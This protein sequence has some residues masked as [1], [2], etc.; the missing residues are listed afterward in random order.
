[1]H[2][3]GHKALCAAT[4]NKQG[5]G[6][7]CILIMNLMKGG[8]ETPNAVVSQTPREPE[9]EGVNQKLTAEDVAEAKHHRLSRNCRVTT[10]R[11]TDKWERTKSSSRLKHQE[12]STLKP[13]LLASDTKIQE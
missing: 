10:N 5:A 3:K 1:V 9:I 7:A 4:P 2:K 6:Q 13:F 8:T 12:Y 11:T